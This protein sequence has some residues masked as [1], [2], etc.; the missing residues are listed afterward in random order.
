MALPAEYVNGSDLLLFIGGIALGHC[1]SFSVD[2]KSETKQ[3]AVKPVST[4]PPGSA[5]FKDATVSNLSISI[6]ADNFL[7]VGETESDYKAYL[8]AWMSAKPVTLELR[9][10]GADESWLSAPFI[11]ESHS[12]TT[13]ADQDVKISGSF[14]IAGAPTVYDA[15]KF[16]I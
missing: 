9:A 11:I 14:V 8:N 12:L 6:K 10:R 3:R 1:S 15:T 13:E 7:Y 16:G 5:K 2:F 4:L